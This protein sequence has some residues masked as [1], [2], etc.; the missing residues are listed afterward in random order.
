MTVLPITKEGSI[1]QPFHG[2]VHSCEVLVR[3]CSDFSCEQDITSE[4]I[5]VSYRGEGHLWQ[6]QRLSTTHA[7]PQVF[8]MHAYYD[9]R[10]VLQGEVYI[11]LFIVVKIAR[12]FHY[13]QYFCQLWTDCSDTPILLVGKL[14]STNG[15][16]KVEVGENFYLNYI[17]S[18]RV[19]TVFV[20]KNILITKVS[21]TAEKCAHS[22]VLVPITYPKKPTTFEHTYG[23][24]EANGVSFGKFG[25][26]QAPWLIEW[27]EANMMFGITEFNIYNSTLQASE[28]VQ[29]VLDYYQDL[30]VLILHQQ[31]P[32]IT[33]YSV[34]ERDVA[35]ISMRTALNDCMYR[36]MYRY[37]YAVTIDLDELIVP[38]RYD[39][40]A[41]VMRLLEEK[42]E[43]GNDS[44]SF[45]MTAIGFYMNFIEG[46]DEKVD[47][48]SPLRSIQYQ[49]EVSSAGRMKTFFNPRHCLGAFS[50]CCL[51]PFKDTKRQSVSGS[52]M[53]VHHYRNSCVKFPDPSD[54]GPTACREHEKHKQHNVRMLHFEARLLSRLQEVSKKL[55]V[56]L[57]I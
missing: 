7:S 54:I 57:L 8:A 18:C 2:E 24:C 43:V 17:V 49:Y 12:A 26:E 15:R 41:D 45:T 48:E 42:F 34:S 33:N 52:E 9:D 10:P 23:M 4:N 3:E 44:I 5:N 51:R 11:R 19:P 22:T 16:R 21:F 6:S 37:K 29:M 56:T 38:Y 55:N 13:I 32:P 40:Y 14:D 50:H 35:D 28:P 30:G 27:F 39:T 36:N 46:Q 20:E 53:M 1:S 47:N 25:P 31:P